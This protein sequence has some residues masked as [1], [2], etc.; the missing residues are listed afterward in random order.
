MLFDVRLVKLIVEQYSFI[1]WHRK[2][3][4]IVIKKH[5]VC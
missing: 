3:A 1:T 5:T 4:V 2:R